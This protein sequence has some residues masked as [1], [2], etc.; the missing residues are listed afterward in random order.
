MASVGHI[1]EIGDGGKYCNC[2]IDP[3]NNFEAKYQV[4]DDKKKVVKELQ[5]QVDLADMVYICSD[6]D[7]EGE[8]IAWSLLTFLNI[9]QGKYK[10]ATFHEITK[11][12]IISGLD[13]ATDIDYNL[14]DSADARRKMDKMLGY[15]L[16]PIGKRY[17]K[18]RSIG[19]CQ[20]AGLLI[21][22]ER[23]KEIQSFVPEEYWELYLHF[24]K[25]K[26]EYKAKYI[27]TTDKKIDKLKNKEEVEKVVQECE[28]NDFVISD[29][30]VKEKL[31]NTKPPFTTSTFQQEVSSKL[32]MSAKSAMS[33]AQ[34]LFEG[35]NVNGEHIG[36][37]T[38]I[39][40][41]SDNMA[42]DFQQELRQY[43]L[44]NYG[45]KYLGN[46][47]QGKKMD[48]AQEGHECLRVVDLNMTPE[49]LSNFIVDK[50]LIKIYNIIYKRTIASMMTP[51]IISETTYLI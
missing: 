7:R 2:G 20:S 46:L 19:R 44:S 30:I 49:K 26:Q 9:P 27:G 35:L 16:S 3:S 23:E 24:I 18:A 21:I 40:T 13:N 38:Y 8:S 25:M 28:G 47:K 32:G 33:C 15:R 11:R 50:N 22:T 43:I 17:V 48:N 6:P 39:R 29:I 14:S 42:E 51:E 10:R 41:D 1:L 34:K 37:I 5:E 12:A 45:D 36:L 4:A 31:T